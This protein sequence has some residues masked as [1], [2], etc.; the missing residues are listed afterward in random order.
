M[1]NSVFGKTMENLSKRIDLKLATDEE[2]LTK[3]ASKQWKS[4]RS[5]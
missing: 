1:N 3:L 4:H 5:T 2:K